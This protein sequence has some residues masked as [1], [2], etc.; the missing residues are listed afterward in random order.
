MISKDFPG[1]RGNMG[2]DEWWKGS[3][4]QAV[5]FEDPEIPTFGT[6]ERCVELPGFKVG[7]NRPG[8]SLIEPG[9]TLAEVLH[10][11]PQLVRDVV[12]VAGLFLVAGVASMMLGRTRRAW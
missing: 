9:D 8:R 12:A 4:I 1:G 7:R 10:V 6:G 2:W 5:G 11:F 3:P